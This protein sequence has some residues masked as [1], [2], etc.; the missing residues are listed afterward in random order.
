MLLTFSTLAQ[1]S[2]TGTWNGLLKIQGVQLRIVFHITSTD[3]GYQTTMDS[4]DQGVLGI[5]ISSTNFEE[6]TLKLALPA[7]GIE[8][9]GKL[10]NEQNISGTFKQAGQSIALNLTKSDENQKELVRPQEPKGPFPYHSEDIAFENKQAGITLVGTL[11]MPQQ[12]GKFPAVVLISGSGPQ[13]RDSEILGHK[14]FWV[15]ADY[16]TRN[17]IAVLRFD[18]RGIGK[19]TGDF[20][21]ATSK[22]FAED[23]MAGVDF[24][25]SKTEIDTHIIGLIGHSE[26]GII[27][28]L[29]A[30]QTKDIAFMVLLGAPGIPCDELMLQQQGLIGKAQGLSESDIEIS[31]AINKGIFDIVKNNNNPD[32]VK[33]ELTKFL[34]EAVKNNSQTLIPEGMTEDEMINAQVKQLINPWMLYFINYNPS[35]VLEQVQCPVLALNG[36]KDLQVAPKENL[37][38]IE[39]A[40]IKGKNNNFSIKVMPGLNHLFQECVTGAPDEYGSIEQTISPDALKEI[41]MWIQALN[42]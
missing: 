28:P 18:E 1:N 38:G 10:E 14:L 35:N 8:Y 12:E 3:N 4:P 24:L 39:S 25:K 32:K 30:A 29:I 16:L 5:A 20:G 11:T 9:E 23:V 41:L 13:N 31:L 26:G 37:A 21:N 42:K 36:E 19:S 34:K 15:I 22:D 27:A 6:T 2:I 7:A 40:L 33:N 17:G